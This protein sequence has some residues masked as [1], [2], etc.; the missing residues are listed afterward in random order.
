MQTSLRSKLPL[1]LCSQIHTFIAEKVTCAF[2]SDTDCL[3]VS[4]RILRCWGHG[5]AV[6]VDKEQWVRVIRVQA[7]HMENR[8]LQWHARG[9]PCCVVQASN[10]KQAKGALRCM[11]F[12]HHKKLGRIGRYVCSHFYC[13]DNGVLRGMPETVV[14]KYLRVWWM[15]SQ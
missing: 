9:S 7:R 10:G 6:E 2:D 12:I 11:G 8:V 13:V 4:E 14:G 15:P 5:C 1:E 3:S